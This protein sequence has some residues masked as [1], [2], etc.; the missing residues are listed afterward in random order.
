MEGTRAVNTHIKVIGIVDP[1]KAMFASNNKISHLKKGAHRVEAGW[2]RVKD[3]SGSI[4]E[5]Y[6]TNVW[7]DSDNIVI[8]SSGKEL[9]RGYNWTYQYQLGQHQFFYDSP[10][11]DIIAYLLWCK[12][13]NKES[14]IKDAVKNFYYPKYPKLDDNLK[15]LIKKDDQ[16]IKKNGG[17]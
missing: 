13:L 11:R 8:N 2:V 16:V 4:S 5:E 9:G 3:A 12:I 10:A 14:A 7:V 15:P 6:R 17:S 1:I